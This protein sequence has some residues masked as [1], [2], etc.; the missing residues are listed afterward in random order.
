MG[1]WVGGRT[2]LE[3]GGNDV[4]RDCWGGKTEAEEAE[5]TGAVAGI[6]GLGGREE[7]VKRRVE[8]GVVQVV[9]LHEDEEAVEGGWVGGGWVG[10]VEEEE[11][12]RM[13][14][15]GVCG[16]VCGGR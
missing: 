12:V 14:C 16:G 5:E 2:N 10:W 8:V 3:E 13:R 6:Q 4:S 1:G 7:G 9:L 15:C 11:A